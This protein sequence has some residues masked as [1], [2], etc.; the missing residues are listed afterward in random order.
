MTVEELV[1]HSAQALTAGA[2]QVALEDCDALLRD[3]GDRP[4]VLR[5]KE[6]VQ[7]TLLRCH[8]QL[9]QWSEAAPLFEVA[10]QHLS[11]A[12]P[13]ARG[14]LLF[15]KAACELRLEQAS[16]ACKSISAKRLLAPIIL[17]GLT[18]LS[19]LTK[20]KRDT[21]DSIAKDTQINVP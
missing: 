20:I 14:E 6:R 5:L 19:V 3:Y 9:G 10:L 4:E 15:H 13:A 16:A 2:W 21:P 8:L 7:L 1:H 12:P 11:E 17:V 18:A